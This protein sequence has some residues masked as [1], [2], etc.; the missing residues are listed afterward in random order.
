MSIRSVDNSFQSLLPLNFSN[1]PGNLPWTS[2]VY[3]DRLSSDQQRF[4]VG[5]MKLVSQMQLNYFHLN[6][7]KSEKGFVTKTW[8]F[9]IV[10]Y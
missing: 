7:K 4:C 3:C 2:R 8:C 6:D 9:L 10:S 5:Q 1:R